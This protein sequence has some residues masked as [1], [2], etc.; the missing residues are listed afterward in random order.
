MKT[1]SKSV[2]DDLD[3]SSVREVLGEGLLCVVMPVY[4]LGDTI[5]ANLDVVAECLDKGKFRY[6]W[7][8]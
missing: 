6:N 2:A 5:E 1:A 4:R 3:W 8:R 7:C